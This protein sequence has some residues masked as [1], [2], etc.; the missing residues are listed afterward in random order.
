[1]GELSEELCID[2]CPYYELPNVFT[3]NADL[4]ND[5]FSAYS[6]R[7]YEC[8][9]EGCPDVP[10]QLTLKCAR[11]VQSVSFTV[12]NR[13]GQEVYDYDGR[14]GDGENNIYI[15]WDGRDDKGTE[16]ASGVYYYVAEVTFDSVDPANQ[17][18]K[19]QRMGSPGS[20]DTGGK[21]VI[22]FDGVC[23]LCNGAVQ[24]INQKG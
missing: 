17:T 6:I 20:I 5:F 8:G 3:P 1:L 22:L 21:I 9:E 12:Y 18:K 19:N 24:F 7:G 23:N 11:F 15:D 2:N 13:W 4:K 14:V 16:M 10:P